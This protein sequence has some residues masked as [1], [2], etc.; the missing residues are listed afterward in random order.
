ML[1]LFAYAAGSR[2]RTMPSNVVAAV[3]GLGPKA[4]NDTRAAIKS[5]DGL[6]LCLGLG[7]S[8]ISYV[9]VLGLRW[10]VV[11]TGLLPPAA[12]L[13]VWHH[14]QRRQ[15][16]PTPAPSPASLLDASLLRERL[17]LETDLPPA[18]RC[19][20]RMVSERLE[21]LRTLA[22]H[23]TELDSGC[24]LPLLVLLERLVD[25][26]TGV[27]GDLRR[28]NQ[29]P[30]EGSKRLYQQRLEALQQQLQ[31]CQDELGHSY[32]AALEDALR[33]P[34]VPATVLLS[35]SLLQS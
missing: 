32:D 18:I 3:T 6:L 21:T 35:P 25:Q 13:V 22:V 14:G 9:G 30:T 28:L 8:T 17:Q 5:R 26:A 23:C 12:V 27:R 34:D 29:A 15:R 10:P 24:A 31:A 33:C 2:F 4:F 16:R 19:Q 7:L 20:W 1:R 11:L